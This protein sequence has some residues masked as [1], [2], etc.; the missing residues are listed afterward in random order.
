MSKY[1]RTGWRNAE[2]RAGRSEGR[3]RKKWWRSGDSRECERERDRGE[4][5]KTGRR[6]GRETEG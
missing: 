4:K 5:T 3:R 1:V 2:G 6:K